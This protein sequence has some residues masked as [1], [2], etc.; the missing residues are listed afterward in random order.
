LHENPRQRNDAFVG[1][2]D[3]T[4]VVGG[5][6]EYSVGDSVSTGTFVGKN[7]KVGTDDGSEVGTKDGSLLSVG[8]RVGSTESVGSRVGVGEGKDVGAEDGV[9]VGK[10]VIFGL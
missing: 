7:V 6:D 2:D 10:M 9:S 8:L 4:L 5:R 3:G 1:E